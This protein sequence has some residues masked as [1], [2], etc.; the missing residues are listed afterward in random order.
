MTDSSEKGFANRR[1]IRSFIIR[2]GRITRGQERALETGWPLFG[3][4]YQATPMDVATT[5]GETSENPLTLEIGFGDGEALFAL[6]QRFSEQNFIGIEV[7]RP[8]VG[9]LLMRLQEAGLSNARVINHDAMDVLENM[10]DDNML[11]RINLYF[12]D[13]WPKKRHHK[14]RIV[15]PDFLELLSRRL[16]NNGLIHFATDWHPYA[17]HM[18]EVL[19]QT[20]YFTNTR[21]DAP[22]HADA[23]PDEVCV[24]RPDSRPLTKFEKRGHRK[25][26]GVWDFVFRKK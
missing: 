16:K 17:E 25:G 9:H 20:P 22:T 5:F 10:V 6:A 13:P 11:D 1:S 19:Q 14:R 21:D 2:E 3:L 18:C 23:T 4:E 8:G 12:P 15:Q 24:P 26:H 7:H